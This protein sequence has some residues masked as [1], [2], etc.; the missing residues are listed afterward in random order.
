MAKKGTIA[1]IPL[2][3]LVIFI[4]GIIVVLY[5]LKN[6][7][8]FKCG[9]A[10]AGAD[11][12]EL[13]KEETYG[14]C[15]E[16]SKGLACD[17]ENVDDLGNE[18]MDKCWDDG[19]DDGRNNPFDHDRNNGCRDYQNMYYRGFI[20]GC[21]SAGNTKEMCASSGHNNY[22]GDNSNEP[23]RLKV[24]ATLNVP[25]SWCGREFQVTLRTEG[26][27]YTEYKDGCTGDVEFAPAPIGINEEF[28]AFSIF[29]DLISN[30]GSYFISL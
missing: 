8:L 20:A 2:G 3:A 29:F 21:E 18:N 12:P 22:S 17:I 16:Q 1:G 7:N 19:Y 24:T 9:P 28:T 25:S 15:E 5:I 4:I 10:T 27:S 6:K 11:L 26:V 13:D 14:I 23:D 30:S